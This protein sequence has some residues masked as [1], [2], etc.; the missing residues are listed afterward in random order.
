M[1]INPLVSDYSLSTR[2]ITII[3]IF[4]SLIRQLLSRGVP[5]LHWS[6]GTLCCDIHFQLHYVC[7]DNVLHQL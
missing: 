7:G 4:L 5:I 6:C 2:E 3:V 1:I